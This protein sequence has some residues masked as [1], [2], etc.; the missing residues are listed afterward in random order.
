MTPQA[1]QIIREIAKEHGVDPARI[2]G[3][4]RVQR[5]FRARVEV[6]KRLR[7]RGYSTTRIGAI[8]NLDHTTIVFYLG[9]G[10][11]KPSPLRVRPVKPPARRR[12][13]KPWIAHLK[14]KGCHRCIRAGCWPRRWLVP[15]AGADMTDYHWKERADAQTIKDQRRG[16]DGA[17][18]AEA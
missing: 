2:T 3:R 14:C 16:Q 5:V 4:C 15:Y 11:R 18:H 17:G 8:L 12:W 7:E 6:A 10:K 1:R 13:H 9:S